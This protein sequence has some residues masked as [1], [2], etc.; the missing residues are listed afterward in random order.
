MSQGPDIQLAAQ[1]MASNYATVAFVMVLLY[2]YVL[3]FA[4][5]VEFVWRQKMGLAKMLF[6][7][8]HGVWCP[9]II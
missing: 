3:T 4:E 9:F 1:T 2:D 8:V 5:E 6:L 7:L